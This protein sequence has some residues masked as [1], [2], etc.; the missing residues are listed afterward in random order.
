M[1]LFHFSPRA[2]ARTHGSGQI[3]PLAGREA[4]QRTPKGRAASLALEGHSFSPTMENPWKL[5]SRP[6]AACDQVD[7]RRAGLTEAGAVLLQRYWFSVRLLF[8]LSAARG[9][10]ACLR[11][12]G[13]RVAALMSRSGMLRERGG[14]AAGFFCLNGILRESDNARRRSLLFFGGLVRPAN[15]SS[16]SLVSLLFAFSGDG[17]IL[18][19][20]SKVARKC[21]SGQRIKEEYPRGMRDLKIKGR[22]MKP[23]SSFSIEH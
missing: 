21:I 12:A 8:C 1:P 19:V 11:V 15:C 16:R 13:F 20:D 5:T 23:E 17:I 3:A 4:G 18:L 6:R 9:A 14:E 22:Y 2:C 7:V 10:G